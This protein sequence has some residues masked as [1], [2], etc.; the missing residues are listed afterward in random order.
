MKN[1]FLQMLFLDLH[2]KDNHSFVVNVEGTII[3]EQLFV[4]ICDLTAT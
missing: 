2:I 1:V 4:S 3:A